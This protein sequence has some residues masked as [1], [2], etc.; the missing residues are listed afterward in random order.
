MC[1]DLRKVLTLIKS[2]SPAFVFF[3]NLEMFTVSCCFER[4]SLLGRVLRSP[5]VQR[6]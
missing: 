4:N 6:D 2:E 1:V 5:E 3:K